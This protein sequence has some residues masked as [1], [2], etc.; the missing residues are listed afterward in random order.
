MGHGSN[1]G[2]WLDLALETPFFLMRTVPLVLRLINSLEFLMQSCLRSLSLPGAQPFS[3]ELNENFVLAKPWRLASFLRTPGNKKKHERF[4]RFASRDISVDAWTRLLFLV[5]FDGRVEITSLEGIL[6][7]TKRIFRT[8]P[9]LTRLKVVSDGLSGPR[10]SSE[11]LPIYFEWFVTFPSKS[12]SEKN[13]SM[14]DE[15]EALGAWKNRVS[16]Y[17]IL[18][19]CSFASRLVPFVCLC[20]LKIS[21]KKSFESNRTSMG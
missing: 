6:G 1:G 10:I 16:F 21:S 14:D 7:W 20:L 19:S 8:L 5:L 2:A 18:M 4:G 11:K 12:A 15:E 17:S 13:E 9:M 3:N